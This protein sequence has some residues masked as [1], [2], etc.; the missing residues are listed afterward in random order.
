M[1]RGPRPVYRQLCSVDRDTPSRVA[2]VG[3]SIKSLVVGAVSG[4]GTS[5]SVGGSLSWEADIAA[6][7]TAV[8]ALRLIHSQRSCR[9][10]GRVSITAAIRRSRPVVLA[11][12]PIA[13]GLSIPCPAICPELRPRTRNQQ[14]H[15]RNAC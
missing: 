13:Y 9:L 7:G 1:K 3:S 5:E 15:R 8:W 14:L 6:P 11:V 4:E 2:R 10:S 12:S